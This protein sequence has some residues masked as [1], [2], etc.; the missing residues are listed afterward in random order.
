VLTGGGTGGHIT[1]ILAVAHALK[2]LQ[3]D[4]RIIYI[5]ERGGKFAELFEGDTSIDEMYTIASGKF[6]RYHGESWL[7]RLFDFKTNLLNL[8]DIFRVCV[9]FVQSLRLLRRLRPDIILLKGGFVGVPVGLAA[10]MRHIPFITHDSDVVPG[11]ANRL[12]SRWARYHATG[13]P[14]SYY[15]YP[16]DSIRYVGVLVSDDYQPV[17]EL[18]QRAFKQAIDVPAGNKLLLITG[19]SLGAQRLNAAVVSFAAE[20]LERYPELTIVHQVGKGNGA[21]YGDFTHERLRVLEFMPQ[22]YRF[23]GA[24][25]VVVTRAGANTL[26]ELGVQGKAA[27][28]VPNPLLTGGHQLRNADYLMGED[29]AIMITEEQMMAPEGLLAAISHLLDNDEHRRNLGAKLHQLTKRDAAQELAQLLIT[30]A[31]R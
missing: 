29:A 7:V 2:R 11:L 5:G 10:A 13:M 16:N 19:G 24:A 30:A 31:G 27:I 20:L 8:R 21:A 1:P 17:D 15:H 3:P 6:R 26:A 22:M 14:P 18:Q 4:M 12:V 25:D 28:I 9:G 23:T